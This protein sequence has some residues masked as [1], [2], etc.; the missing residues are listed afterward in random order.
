MTGVI[1]PNAGSEGLV[2]R[3][4]NSRGR[5]PAPVVLML[6]AG[7]ML[8]GVVLATAAGAAPRF[9]VINRGP[10]TGLI[11]VPDGFTATGPST[12]ELAWDIASHSYAGSVAVPD[13][14]VES[15]GFDGE[16]HALTLRARHAVHSRLTL[17]LEAPWIAHGGGFLDRGID[18]WHDWFG[19][20]EGVRPDQPTDAL[21]HEYTGS[22]A[23][24]LIDDA[25]CGLG[26][27]RTGLAWRAFGDDS[28]ALRLDLIVEAKLPSGDAQR[29]TGSGGTDVAAGIRLSDASAANRFAWSLGMGAVAVGDTDEPLPPAE[30]RIAWWDAALTWEA[31]QALDLVLQWQGQ[32]AAWES[33]LEALGDA[34]HQLGGGVFWQVAPS[35]RLQ[36]GI[37]E[38]ISPDTAPDFSAQL[39]LRWE[40][41]R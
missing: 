12:I 31:T 26:D 9:H 19:L 18:R 23:E 11:G 28:G 13:G 35:W 4:G 39:G 6:S 27:L 33:R 5:R 1:V 14:P 21:R 36:F 38:D 41:D 25:T 8:A 15:A 29:L 3:N 32:T 37:F 16:T 40:P 2:P 10:L 34:G 22:G 24:L 17:T 7:V 30:D 20:R